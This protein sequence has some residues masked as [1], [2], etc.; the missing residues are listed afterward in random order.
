MTAAG[1]SGF[2]RV[3]LAVGAPMPRP[4][5]VTAAVDLAAAVGAALE[6]LFVESAELLR[7]SALPEAHETSPL[8]GARRRLA[9]DD[10]ERAFRIEAAHLERLLAAQAAQTSVAWSFTITRGELSTLAL[11]CDAEL[12]VVE[13]TRRA[14]ALARPVRVEGPLMALFD[15]TASARRG[16]AATTRLARRTGRAFIVLVPAGNTSTSRS[17]RSA[18]EAWLA[19]ED[20]EAI[21]LPLHLGRAEV[22][23]TARARRCALL[24]LPEPLA[25][26]WSPDVALL[27]DATP[28]PLVIAR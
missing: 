28:C 1:P 4:A 20:G 25:S 17:A 16:L 22:L 7:V 3:V 23:A 21:L 24:M 12:I 2:S 18:V 27:A 26:T 15:G 19:A 6:G 11:A 8:T 5:A 9:M 13:A 14:T 10:L